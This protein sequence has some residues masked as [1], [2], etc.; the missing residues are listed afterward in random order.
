[1]KKK[2]LILNKETI[3]KLQDL[4]LK[5]FKG[6][7][8]FGACNTINPECN[9]TDTCTLIPNCASDNCTA[10]TGCGGDTGGTGGSGGSNEEQCGGGVSM[11][12]LC[13]TV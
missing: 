7:D 10:E 2:K 3:S 5:D 4:D 13:G 11:V 1:M 6:G 9:T 8:T 12:F